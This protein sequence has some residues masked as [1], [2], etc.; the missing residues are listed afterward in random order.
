MK[1]NLGGSA[2]CPACPVCPVC[3]ARFRGSALCS[4]CGAD[5]T[6]LMLLTTHA[7]ALRQ[8]AR[9]SLRLGDP[10]AAL[11]SA[12]AGQQLHSTAEGSLLLL[13]SSA[14]AQER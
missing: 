6:A 13:V 14:I 3:Q 8:S 10:T 4:R 9:R 11:A 7:H 2:S 5:L 12:R 1:D